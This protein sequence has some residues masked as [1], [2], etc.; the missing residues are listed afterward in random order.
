L[1]S[2]IAREARHGKEAAGKYNQPRRSGAVK[3]FRELAI[4]LEIEGAQRELEQAVRKLDPSPR[5][6]KQPSLQRKKKAAR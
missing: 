2:R 4:E 6:P 1:N 5:S 3:R